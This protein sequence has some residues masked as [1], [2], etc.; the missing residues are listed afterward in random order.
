MRSVMPPSAHWAA[1][2][3]PSA[4]LARSDGSVKG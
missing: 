2:E 4:I 3:L 1:G